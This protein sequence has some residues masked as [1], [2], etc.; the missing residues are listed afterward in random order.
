MSELIEHLVD[1]DSALDEALRVLKP[2]GSLLLST[3]NLA[4]WYN[5][6]L[7]ALG[8][9]PIFSEV[10]LRGVYGR[11]GSVVAGHLHMFTRGALVGPAGRPRVHRHRRARRPLSR[12]AP[13]AAPRG[14]RALRLARRPR[15]SCWCTPGNHDPCG[16]PWPTPPPGPRRRPAGAGGPGWPGQAAWPALAGLGLGLLALGPGLGPRL[17]AQLRH[18]VRAADAVLGRADRADRRAAARR[19][20][21]RRGG[22]GVAGGTRRHPA[23]ADPAADLRPGLLGR[24]RPARQ[25]LEGGQPE[26]PPG[27]AAGGPAGRGGGAAGGPAGGR[28]VLRLEP[29]PGRAAADRPVG[30]AARATPRCRG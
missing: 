24:R 26:G 27:G 10:S 2:G 23:E 17:P 11:P 21:R 14:P 18:G 12:R 13:A 28:G 5:R 25:R 3:P 19:A 1:T 29:V 15:R 22:R 7:L 16:A 4:A 20:Q 6:G 8:V 30:A 9:Q